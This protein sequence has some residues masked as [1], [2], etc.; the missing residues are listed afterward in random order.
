MRS[1]AKLSAETFGAFIDERYAP[2]TREHAGDNVAAGLK[3]DFA[4]WLSEPLVTLS[5]WHIESWRRDQRDLR[6][7]P[8][9]VS[10]QLQAL[11]NCLSKA[12]EWLLIER[13]PVQD[14]GLD[15]D[16]GYSIELFAGGIGHGYLGE[17]WALLG[18]NS[19]WTLGERAVL[20]LPP[21]SGAADYVLK[22]HIDGTCM[23]SPQ[24]LIVAVNETT[25][26]VLLCRGPAFNEFFVPA[27]V[28]KSRNPNN[29]V[30]TIPDARRPMDHEES[31]DNR[32]LGFRVAKIELQPMT[33]SQPAKQVQPPA[34][35]DLP[36][37]LEQRA[38]LQEMVSLGFNCELGFVQRYV[39]A[40][41][42]SLFRWSYVPLD[43]L[44][45][46]L[47]KRFAGLNAREALDVQVTP[48]GEFV[49]ESKVYGFRHHT[50]VFAFQ[51]GVREQVQ[52]NEYLRVGI[53]CKTLLEELREQKK[54][55]VYHD[56]DAS[57]LADIRRLVRALHIYGNN[58]LLWIV[59][60]VDTA[61][62]GET[63]QIEP[64]L[65]QGYVSGFQTGPIHP[66][67]PHRPSW[68]QVACR[69]HQIWSRTKESQERL[70]LEVQLR[71]L[72]KQ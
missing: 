60:A 8:L 70:R 66:G 25:V 22:M 45:E 20:E 15:A 72:R 68:T 36:R 4:H 55:F 50:F 65:I 64:G 63:R 34:A 47:E 11:D 7:Q 32:F 16:T 3:A 44:I 39:G 6:A 19:T 61:Q 59:G 46:A 23:R 67:S 2:W 5:A 28:L 35:D 27:N 18:V 43:K 24:R 41:P 1:E 33:K 52:R 21:I 31:T 13:N 37:V 71:N 69:A 14:V 9:I 57:K 51:G 62:I 49:V 42:M 29:V 30:L 54:L 12:V 48:E 38:A 40:E 26:G 10:R 53:L 17:G 56:A 58:T